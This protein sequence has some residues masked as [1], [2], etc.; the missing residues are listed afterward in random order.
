MNMSF[1]YGDDVREAFF[2]TKQSSC[3]RETAS[4]RRG[5]QRH[6]ICRCDILEAQLQ[7]AEDVRGRLGSP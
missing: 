2:A 7:S 1:P 5:S 4:P 6:T 3:H